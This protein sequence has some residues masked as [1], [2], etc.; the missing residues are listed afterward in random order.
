MS[1]ADDIAQLR[2][3]LTAAI[4]AAADE[5][6]LEAVRVA[7]LGKKGSVSALLA[8]LG[9][10]PPEDRKTAGPVINGLKNEIAGLIE[11][12]G[13]ELRANALEA[14]LQSE[15]VDVTLPVRAAPT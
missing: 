12:K 13:A 4:A 2:T 5:P 9:T 7:A 6:A 3:D 8:T 15:R 14:R 1:L 11:A 10:M